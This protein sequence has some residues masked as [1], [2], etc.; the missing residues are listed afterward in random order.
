LGANEDFIKEL[1]KDIQE[2]EKVAR[3]FDGISGELRFKDKN[4]KDI[5]VVP[6][7]LK[8]QQI[9]GRINEHRALIEEL[10]KSK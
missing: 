5:E 9:R 3:Y 4:E 1:E 8:A 2:W 7:K 10:K 6:A